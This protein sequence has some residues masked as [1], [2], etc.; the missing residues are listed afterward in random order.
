MLLEMKNSTQ[1]KSDSDI[2]KLT[3]LNIDVVALLGHEHVDLSH[4]RK[5]LIKPHTRKDFAGLYASHVPVTALLFGNNLKTQLD[6]IRASNRV[7]TTAPGSRLKNNQGHFTKLS[8]ILAAKQAFFI[9]RPSVELE[10]T[11]KTLLP[12]RCRTRGR[13]SNDFVDTLDN[14]E[15]NNIL[16]F[17]SK[18]L[19]F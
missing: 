11:P 17:E 19:F 9:K 1:P 18:T 14:L 12:E 3:K 13:S 5:E 4:R 10:A 15:V 7:S 2:Q 8:K 6:N 16:L